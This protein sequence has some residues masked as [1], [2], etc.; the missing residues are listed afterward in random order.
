MQLVF[1][2]SKE[3]PNGVSH[4][5]LS[6]CITRD[7][8]RKLKLLRRYTCAL[9]L[10]EFDIGFKQSSH[11]RKLN[12][13]GVMFHMTEATPCKILKKLQKMQPHQTLVVTSANAWTGWN[14]SIPRQQECNILKNMIGLPT[15]PLINVLHVRCG[16][17]VS[18]GFTTDKE[19]TH[20]TPDVMTKLCAR[21]RNEFNDYIVITDSDRL[22]EMLHKRK[23]DEY[24]RHSNYSQPSKQFLSD[25]SALIRAKT[26]INV[27]NYNQPSCF[28]FLFSRLSHG[29]YTPVFISD[30]ISGH[31]IS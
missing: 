2:F 7:Y 3:C 24:R 26:V 14:I 27:S 23:C 31:P 15:Q 19:L 25:V 11:P 5:I 30:F 9:D 20:V 28:S 13:I 1:K 12:A 6:W 8:L 18:F 4:F 16:D 29:N 17:T 22:Y 21:I 10:T